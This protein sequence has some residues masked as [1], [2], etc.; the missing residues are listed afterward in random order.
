MLLVLGYVSNTVKPYIKGFYRASGIF[1]QQFQDKM[2]SNSCLISEGLLCGG[3]SQNNE[4]M[5]ETL[6][7][8]GQ[9]Y[10]ML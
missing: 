6:G 5:K 9:T 2:V 8:N 3:I 4:L 7:V 1:T 10:V